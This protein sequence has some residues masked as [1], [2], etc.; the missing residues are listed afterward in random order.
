MLSCAGALWLAL[1]TMATAASVE[2]TVRET[3]GQRR[4]GYPVTASLELP[5]SALTDAAKARL[6]GANGREVVAQFT[7]LSKWPDGSVRRLDAD[8]NSSIGPRET[9]LYRV[10]LGGAPR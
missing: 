4:F 10:E 3:A 5:Q 9:E 6:H 7:A 2:F 8:F 1:V